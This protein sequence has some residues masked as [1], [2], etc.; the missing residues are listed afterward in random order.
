[1]KKYLLFAG[2][3]YY[4]SGGVRDFVGDFDSIEGAMSELIR[5]G[6]SDGFDWYHIVEYSTMKIVKKGNKK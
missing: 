1:M 5:F 6:R 4:P 2:D 3:H